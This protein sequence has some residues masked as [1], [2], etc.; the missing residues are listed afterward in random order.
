MDIRPSSTLAEIARNVPASI[1]IFERAGIDYCC[2]GA[3]TLQDAANDAGLSVP[4]V[5]EEIEAAK[6]AP[7]EYR[8][9]SGET[10]T[11]MVEFLIADHKT[12]IEV[13]MPTVRR[14]IATA[15]ARHGSSPQL[16]R[17]ERLFS[18]FASMSTGHMLNEERDL[19]PHV[20]TLQLANDGSTAPPTLRIS[21]RVLGEFVEHERIHEQL[22]TMRELALEAAPDCCTLALRQLLERFTRQ[23]HHHVHLENNILY[24]RAIAIENQLR[25]L[26]LV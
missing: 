9:W 16:L 7:S 15:M 18:R 24:P 3:N 23:V 20:E 10:L 12:T 26:Q 21:H 13:A 8:D 14:A 4:V 2:R 19:L 22:R 17:M 11:S 6:T 5:L 25:K 1:E